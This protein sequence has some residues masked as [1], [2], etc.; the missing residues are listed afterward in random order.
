LRVK[1]RHR[2]RVVLGIALGIGRLR[3]RAADDGGSAETGK[4]PR[5]PYPGTVTVLYHLAQAARAERDEL[6]AGGAAPVIVSGDIDAGSS[7]FH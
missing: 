5:L 2:Y 3:I 4:L 7:C 6:A 1:E